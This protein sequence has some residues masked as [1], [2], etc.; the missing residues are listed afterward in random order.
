MLLL[1]L[2]LISSTVL[3]CQASEPSVRRA[4]IGMTVHYR[5]ADTANI[6]RQFDLMAAMGVKWVRVDLGWTWIES[7]RGTYD[8]SYSDTVVD[9]ARARGMNVLVVLASTPAWARSSEAGHSGLTHSSRPVDLPDYASFARTAAERYVPLGVRS[10]EIWNEP[11]IRRFWPPRPDADEYGELF[12]LAAEAIRSVDPDV[13][14]LIG[15]LSPR[16]DS[17][18]SEIAPVEYLESLYDNGAAQLADGVAIHPYTFP[19]LPMAASE[20]NIIGG[21][22][23]LPAL[24]DVMDRRGDGGKKIWITEY[25]APTGTGQYSVSEDKQAATLVQAREQFERWD[26]AGPLIY[27]ELVDGGGDLRGLLHE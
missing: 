24:H 23:D 2:V 5:Q 18:P 20:R 19:A 26:W 22:P 13:S 10:W 15:G 16:Y 6:T 17:L 25:G 3:S 11:N 9:E 12:R 21:F 27:Y 7:E 8:W 4:E 1:T 14:I